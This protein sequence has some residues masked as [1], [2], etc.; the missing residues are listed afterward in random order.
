MG[1]NKPKEIR[2]DIYGEIT[3]VNEELCVEYDRENFKIETVYLWCEFLGEW[4][5]VKLD[6]H[7]LGILQEKVYQHEQ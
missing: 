1:S 2:L 3:T 7:H 4:L 5:E 6:P